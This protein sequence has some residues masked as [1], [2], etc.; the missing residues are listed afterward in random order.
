LKALSIILRC[1]LLSPGFPRGFPAED[2]TVTILGGFDNPVMSF[3]KVTQTVLMPDVSR[4]LDINP[5]D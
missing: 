3:L 2:L 5:T 1:I 4:V